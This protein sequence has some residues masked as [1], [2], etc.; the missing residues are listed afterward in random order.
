MKIE[1][2]DT[3]EV[4]KLY[5]HPLVDDYFA[6]D[7]KCKM[8]MTKDLN[9]SEE[10]WTIARISVYEVD[11][12]SKKFGTSFVDTGRVGTFLKSFFKRIDKAEGREFFTVEIAGATRRI[13]PEEIIK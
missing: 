3:F 1:K 9:W 5:S 8:K 4:G 2:K 7:G 10:T 12:F 11:N 13:Y 6:I